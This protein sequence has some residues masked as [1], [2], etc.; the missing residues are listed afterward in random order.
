[1]PIGSHA[2]EA[3]G[4]RSDKTELLRHAV[5]EQ[6]I[7]ADGSIMVGDRSHDV[8]AAK[9]MGMLAVGVTWGFGGR[10]EL[11]DAQADEIIDTQME[12]AQLIYTLLKSDDR[13][14]DRA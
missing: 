1:M 9:R 11:E 8:I 7:D 2:S 3:D 10:Q 13:Q 12:L 6:N 5:A 14:G 4:T